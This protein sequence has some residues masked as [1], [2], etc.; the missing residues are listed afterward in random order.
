VL[1]PVAYF[2]T[3]YVVTSATLRYSVPLAPLLMLFAS[4][5]LLDVY[6]RILGRAKFLGARAITL[7]EE[8]SFSEPSHTGMRAGSPSLRR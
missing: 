8:L 4:I 7:Q 3:I 6:S 1:L 2:T 5:G